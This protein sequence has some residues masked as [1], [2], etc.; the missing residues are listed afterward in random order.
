MARRIRKFWRF[1]RIPLGIL[2]VLVA[3]P[4]LLTPLYLVVQPVSVP[5]LERYVTGRPV[6]RV[7]RDIDDISD[8][9][10]AAIILSEDGQ[11]CRHWGI[12]LGALR[13]EVD[14]YLAGRET[15]GASTITM[16]VARNL[17]LWN[18]QSALRKALE[19]PLAAYIDLVMP[20]K[21]IMEIYLN[22]AEWG[23][24]GQFGVAAGSEHAF[25]REPQNLDWQTASLLAVTLPNPLVRNPARPNAGLSRVASIVEER[26]RQYGDRAA[27][28]GKDGRLAL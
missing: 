18:R 10:K 23:P 16:Q 25:G 20:K 2:A 19:V 4:L 21:R 24:S 27:C 11:F 9:L 5:M 14:N 6:V 22:I 8:R 12:D 3:I 26:T 17:F 13:D 1:L 15:R 7:W 28:V